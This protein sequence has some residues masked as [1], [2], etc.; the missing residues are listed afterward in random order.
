MKK[1]YNIDKNNNY[2]LNILN[3]IAF[4]SQFYK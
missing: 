2:E 4:M 1:N 3:F